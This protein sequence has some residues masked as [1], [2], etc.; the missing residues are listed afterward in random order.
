MLSKKQKHLNFV[1]QR[2]FTDKV[3]LTELPQLLNLCNKY[4]S[5]AEFRALGRAIKRV[6]KGLEENNPFEL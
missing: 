4:K 2:Y 5:D 3:D 6:I 1:K